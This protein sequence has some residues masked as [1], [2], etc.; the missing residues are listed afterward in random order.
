MQ[1]VYL[2]PLIATGS[3]FDEYEPLPLRRTGIE[4]LFRC[5]ANAIGDAKYAQIRAAGATIVVALLER[6]TGIF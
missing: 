3:E 4:A 6:K 2:P 1:R 5:I